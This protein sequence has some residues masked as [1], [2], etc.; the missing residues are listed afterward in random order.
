MCWNVNV[1]V[2]LQIRPH[3]GI[4][5]LKEVKLTAV[6][7]GVEEVEYH[8]SAYLT[9]FDRRIIIVIN[10]STKTRQLQKLP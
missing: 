10:S 4:R 6:L 2:I 5:I 7:A 3:T 8:L 9:I 1:G